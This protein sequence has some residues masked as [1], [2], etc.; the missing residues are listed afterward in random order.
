MIPPGYSTYVIYSCINMSYAP[1]QSRAQS[2]TSQSCSRPAAAVSAFARRRLPYGAGQRP[3]AAPGLSLS[4]TSSASEAAAS[5]QRYQSRFHREAFSQIGKA[6]PDSCPGDRFVLERVR[7]PGVSGPANAETRAWLSGVPSAAS[8]SCNICLIVCCRISWN[9]LISCWSPTMPARLVVRS[10]L[11]L[12]R[13]G[14]TQ[15]AAI[16]TRVSSDRQKEEHTIASQ[17]A[18]LLEYAQKHGYVVPPEWVFQDEGYSGATL[19]RPGLE[20]LRDLAAQGQ[21][22]AVL[23]YSPDRLSRK[24]AYRI[25]LAE[26]LARCGVELIFLRAPSGATAEDQ[27]LVQFQG[28]IAEYERAQI[29]E[30]SRRG[31]RHH[32]QQGSINVLSGAPYGYRYV[33]KTDAS[34]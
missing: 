18:A 3:L 10:L 19:I 34:A 17:T 7:E 27:L 23:V 30:R 32:A 12:R 8:F 26:E 2:Q 4:A 29:A 33:K 6:S 11:Y 16:Y 14:M 31:K 28:M 15:A 25:L 1:R 21:M 22:V 20:A 24:Y 5:G 13:I 9:R